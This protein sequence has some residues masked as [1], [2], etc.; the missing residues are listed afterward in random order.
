MRDPHGP[1]LQ[2]RGAV[3]SCQRFRR[4]LSTHQRREFRTQS[5]HQRTGIYGRNTTQHDAVYVQHDA[6]HTHPRVSAV[7]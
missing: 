5:G 2:M 1:R 4:A 7:E 3:M 6:R